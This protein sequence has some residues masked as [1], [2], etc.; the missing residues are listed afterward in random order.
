MTT[1][2]TRKSGSTISSARPLSPSRRRMASTRS[3]SAAALTPRSA[4]PASA[5][6]IS[7]SARR[8]K[9]SGSMRRWRRRS[10]CGSLRSAS[11]GRSIPPSCMNSRAVSI[12]SSAWKKS[13]TCSRRMCANCCSTI[14]STPSSWARRTSRAKHLFPVYGTLEPNQI[15]IAIGERI[16]GHKHS[17][18]VAER[19]AA[20]KNAQG[21]AS[22]LPDLL[23]RMPYFCAGCPHNSST[24]L[25]EDARG[26]AGIGCHWMVQSMPSRNTH[27]ST[28]M[29]GEGAN[30]VGEAPF[31]KRKHIFQNLGDGTY[32]HSGLLAHPRRCRRRCEHHLQDPLQ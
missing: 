17:P 32:N 11:S 15:A 12:S 9:S 28:Q 31:S 29:G 19:L 8:W 4:L 2:S 14:A 13:A 25:P 26:Y 16:L 20:I 22:N 24:V 30:W 6:A 18:E 21:G 1:G 7:I 27:G 10:A 23:S 5:R 3:C